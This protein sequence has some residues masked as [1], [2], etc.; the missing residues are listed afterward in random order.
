MSESITFLRSDG[1]PLPDDHHLS[2]NP[3]KKY[4]LQVTIS[5]DTKLS[6]KR[7]TIQLRTS[8]KSAAMSKRDT[9]LEAYKR[10]GI[11]C[12]DMILIE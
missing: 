3:R 1:I 10:A 9:I 4:V 6:G 11:I 5:T 2:L 7:I 8:D 12:R